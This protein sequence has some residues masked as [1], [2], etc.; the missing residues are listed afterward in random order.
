[1]QGIIYDQSKRI[2]ADPAGTDVR[3]QRMKERET[4][5][6]RA[7]VRVKKCLLSSKESVFASYYHVSL[8]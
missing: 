4:S 3:L 5:I 7:R 2:R 8:L 1:M 6:Q